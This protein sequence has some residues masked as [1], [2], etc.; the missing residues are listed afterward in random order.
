MSNAAVAGWSSRQKLVAK[1]STEAEIVALSDA[2]THVLWAREWIL[3]QGYDPGAVRVYQDN[4]SVLSLMETGKA[5]SHR[6]K[7]LKVRDFFAKS[8]VSAGEIELVWCATERMLA[9]LMTKPV[10]GALFRKLRDT[11]NGEGIESANGDA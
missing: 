1:S 9:D 10:Q 7:H 2:M 11:L 8:R 4:R 6:T 3:F 5:P